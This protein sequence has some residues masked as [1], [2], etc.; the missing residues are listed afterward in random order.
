MLCNF[1]LS[2]FYPYLIGVEDTVWQ[3]VALFGGCGKSHF[4]PRLVCRPYLTVVCVRARVRRRGPAV[5]GCAMTRP[6]PA[7]KPVKA[8]KVVDPSRT[9]AARKHQRRIAE[10]SRR[11]ATEAA[12]IRKAV[13][14]YLEHVARQRRAL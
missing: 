4:S 3:T 1:L 12:H 6:K 11:L 8:A 13:E 7:Q 5:R 14:E 10:L 2:K 9:V